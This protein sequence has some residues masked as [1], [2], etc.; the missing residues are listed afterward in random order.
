MRRADS[1]ISKETCTIIKD[2]L[3]SRYDMPLLAV[4][5]LWNRFCN[6]T[7]GAEGHTVEPTKEKL[8]EFKD[9]LK[10]DV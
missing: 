3:M 8:K 2:A 9:W 6:R 5:L 10:E 1:V 7:M 4:E